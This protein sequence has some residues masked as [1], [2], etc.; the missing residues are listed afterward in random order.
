MGRLPAEFAG[1]PITFRIPYSMPG[2]LLVA[3]N[4]QGNQF[5][6]ATFLHNVDKPFEIHRVLVRLTGFDNQATPV[7]IPAQ[8]ANLAKLVRLRLSDTSKNETLTK[9]AHLVDTLLS[10]NTETWEWEDP[11]TL[12]RS[13]GFSVQVDA[14]ALGTV[15]SPDNDCNLAQ[16]TVGNVRVELAFQGYLIVIAPPSEMR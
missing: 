7:M 1:K 16:V 10:N 6:D 9:A 12:V 5:P 8:P 11:Y 13:E 4:T 14:Q 3:S 15:C 2:E